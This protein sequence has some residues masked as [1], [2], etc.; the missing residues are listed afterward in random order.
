MRFGH[1]IPAFPPK[2]RALAVTCILVV[3]ELLWPPQTGN[4]S[5]MRK[6][7]IGLAVAFGLSLAALGVI[8]T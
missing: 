5:P 2:D 3:L 6:A 1:S 4:V 7:W 8:W